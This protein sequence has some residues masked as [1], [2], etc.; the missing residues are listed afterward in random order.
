MQLM[1]DFMHEFHAPSDTPQ[2]KR[3]RDLRKPTKPSW[4]L[5]ENVPTYHDGS[6]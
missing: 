5:C 3:D 2:M 1:F 4:L 6:L